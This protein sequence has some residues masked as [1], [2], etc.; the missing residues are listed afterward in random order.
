M[1]SPTS[2]KSE[3][4]ALNSSEVCVDSSVLVK[5]AIEEEHSDRVV[6][7]WNGW[8]AAGIRILAPALVWYELTSTVRKRH[9]RGSLEDDE[10]NDAIELLLGLPL[11]DVTGEEL[12]RAAYGIATQLGELVTYDSHYLAVATLTSCQLWTADR[13]MHDR[14]TKLRITSELIGGSA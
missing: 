14:A 9:H 6:D 1:P 5:L 3:M 11:V 12:H 2:A 7:I 10:A 4:S 8:A 13:R